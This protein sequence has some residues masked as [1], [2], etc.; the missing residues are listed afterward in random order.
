[1]IPVQR[2]RR[3]TLWIT[4]D[5]ELLR[6]YHDTQRWSGPL[7]V[8]VDERGVCRGT[9]NRTLSSML[10]EA[11][12]FRG[13]TATPPPYLRNARSCL[14]REPKDVESFATLCGVKKST[15]WCYLCQVVE[16]WPGANVV[17]RRYV[18]PPL[19]EAVSTTTDA[20]GSLKEFMTRLEQGPLKGDSDWKCVQD[21]HAHLRLARL[22]VSDASV[23][24]RQLSP[25]NSD[26]R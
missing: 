20:T 21:R 11:T 14:S 17:A 1:M 19:L 6:Q 2:G 10:K 25:P 24:P 3:S 15:A 8:H 26:A 13:T 5:S 16:H 12:T 9:G 22:C 7:N 23:T 4:E 18:Y